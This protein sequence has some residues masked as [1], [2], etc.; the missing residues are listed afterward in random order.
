[1]N[2]LQVMQTKNGSKKTFR[3]PAFNFSNWNATINYEQ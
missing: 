3:Y 2:T 1:M